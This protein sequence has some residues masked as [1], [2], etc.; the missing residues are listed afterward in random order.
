MSPTTTTALPKTTLWLWPT[1]LFPRRIIYYLRA[2]HITLS[3]L[4]AHNIHLIPIILSPT[5]ASLVAKPGYEARP[6]DTSLPC[7]RVEKDDDET[8][9][10]HESLSIVGWLEEVFDGADI[11]GSTISQRA[12]TRDILSLLNDALAWSMA[13]MIHSDPRTLAWS[14]LASASEQSPSAAAHAAKKFHFYLQRLENWVEG[15][16]VGKGTS[17][18]SGEG[19]GVTLADVVLMSQVCYIEEMYGMDWVAEHGVLRVWVE[20]AKGEAWWVGRE[21]LERCEKEEDWE[22]VLGK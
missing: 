4:T 17:S 1:G 21:A 3:A 2:K 10:V 22:G 14:G 16:V 13:E 18:L 8:L 20:R 6:A 11:Y 9:W 5:T 19:A 7:M 15:D 12:K